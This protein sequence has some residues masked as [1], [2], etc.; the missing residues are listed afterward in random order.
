[1]NIIPFDWF[2]CLGG[3]NSHSY[4]LESRNFDRTSFGLKEIQDLLQYLSIC[5][6]YSRRKRVS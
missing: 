6:G 1:M 3:G 4:F 5:C 2:R